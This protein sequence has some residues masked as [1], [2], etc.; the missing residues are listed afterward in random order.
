M[1]TVAIPKNLISV[2]TA[3]ETLGVTTGRI[4]QLL[5]AEKLDGI[6]LNERAWVVDRVSLDRVAKI[7]QTVGRPRSRKK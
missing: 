6:K 4:R 7:E 2:E 1:S 5:R 3:A